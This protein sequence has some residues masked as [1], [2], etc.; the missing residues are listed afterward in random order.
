[1]VTLN[2]YKNVP[3]APAQRPLAKVPLHTLWE[4]KPTLFLFFRRLGCALCRSYAK[5]M[6]A[7]RP[8]LEQ[9]GIQVIGM[10]FE[11]FGEGS[12]SDHSF[13]KGQFWTGP[14]Y[15]ID[16][17]VYEKMFGRKGLTDSFFGL[18]DMDKSAVHRTKESGVQG[19]YRG[20]G[21]QLG[22]QILVSHMGDVLFEHKQKRYGDDA[23]P[24]EIL[25]AIREH[26]PGA[27]TA[28]QQ[29]V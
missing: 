25:Q 11:A 29:S 9:A 17:R 19:N 7:Y 27:S 20:D 23:T 15:V 14:L 8:S 24:E 12:D 16:K 13:E 5:L 26:I 21:F 1:M 2:T 28:L 6:D 4:R 22:G 10:S 3:V 18:L